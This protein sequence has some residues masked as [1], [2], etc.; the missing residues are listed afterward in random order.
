MELKKPRR[1]FKKIAKKQNSIS[2]LLEAP[3][4]VHWY[5]ERIPND[6]KYYLVIYSW[7]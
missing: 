7:T 6:I 4:L 2:Q 3:F 1:T 5:V